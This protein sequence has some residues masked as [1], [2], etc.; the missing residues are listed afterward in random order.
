MRSTLDLRT[1]VTLSDDDRSYWLRSVSL[2][3]Q[4]SLDR[5]ITADV[6]IIGG[7]L[8]GLWSAIRIAEADPSK[9]VVILEASRCGDGASGRNGG[10]LHSWFDSLERLTQVT[11]EREALDLASMTVEAIEELR[12]LQEDQGY[13]LGLR[14]DGWLWTASARSQEGSWA[15][16]QE[17][18]HQNGKR[19][20]RS[21]NGDEIQNRTG[22]A[23]SYLGVEEELAGTVHPGKLVHSLVR[24]ALTK[25]VTIYE[26]S[27]VRSIAPGN[28]VVATT[29]HAE[30]T[31][32]SCVIA[33]NAWA[34]SIPDI[35]KYM[36]TVDSQVIAT[37]PIP[38]RLDA[39]GWRGGEAICDSQSQVLYYQRT[40]EGRVV[41]GRGSGGPVYRDRLGKKQNRH[42]R[43]KKDTIAEFHRVYPSLK[44]VAIAH[45]WVG[46]IDCVPSHVP[47]IGHLRGQKNVIYAVGWNGTGLAQIPACS[48][49]IA[50][51]ALG[52]DD[53]WSQS[54]LVNQRNLKRLPPEPIRFIGAWF[55]RAAVVQQNR[56]AIQ[57]KRANPLAALIVKLM[58]KGTSEHD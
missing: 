16:T 57:N 34:S 28:P 15:A 7:G 30:V 1:P 39:I 44:D 36:Y 46:A 12:A 40:V 38:R 17:H 37:E 2:S 11:G 21:I 3:P 33:T 19:P 43:W 27:A 48:R 25:G 51:L 56:A 18:A 55:V 24:Y 10:Q 6:V 22:S 32:A 35:R 45:D 49:I 41:F 4:P 20:Y 14:L 47:I 9:K 13:D 29:E 58:P 52:K 53:R 31:A 50:S 42:P 23:V 26:H 5:S 54:S 8:T